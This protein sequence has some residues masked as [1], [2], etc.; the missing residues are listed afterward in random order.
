MVS[1]WATANRI[2]LGRVV[3]DEESNEI[4]AI[5][6]LLEILL[7]ARGLSLESARKICL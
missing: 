4:T 6:K 7:A 3:V 2:S 5:P 1:A